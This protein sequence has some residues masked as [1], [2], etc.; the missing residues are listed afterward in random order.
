MR[1]PRADFLQPLEGIKDSRIA[2]RLHHTDGNLKF[3]ES[4]FDFYTKAFIPFCS[5]LNSLS[6]SV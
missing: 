3:L 4:F 1:T 5:E 2:C 6:N